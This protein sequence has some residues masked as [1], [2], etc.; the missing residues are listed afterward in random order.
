[1]IANKNL[2]VPKSD[3]RKGFED[4]V[5]CFAWCKDGVEMVG[6]TGKTLAMALEQLEELYGFN[7]PPKTAPLAFTFCPRCG[8]QM[9]PK[10]DPSKVGHWHDVSMDNDL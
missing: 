4:G 3:Y 8:E 7:P 5:R 10:H 2:D 1:M 6:T 9:N